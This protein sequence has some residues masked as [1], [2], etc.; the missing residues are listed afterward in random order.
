MYSS[1][2]QNS[3]FPFRSSIVPMIGYADFPKWSRKIPLGLLNEKPGHYFWANGSGVIWLQRK[4]L[5]LR[6]KYMKSCFNNLFD[7]DI[8]EL[9]NLKTIIVFSMIWGFQNYPRLPLFDKYYDFRR[10]QAL[11][12]SRSSGI[13]Y[14][15]IVE[16]HWAKLV[17][18]FLKN[19][20]DYCRLDT[21][22]L[23]TVIYTTVI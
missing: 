3:Y 17:F 5:E 6:K 22:I 14:K 23:T 10:K 9:M 21:V 8:I 7:L 18:E 2:W 1:A 11:L 15:E 13:C 4:Q 16:S 19:F 12:H 20:L